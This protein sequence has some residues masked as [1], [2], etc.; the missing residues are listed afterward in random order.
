MCTASVFTAA[1]A[2]K[3]G[4]VDSDG[5][6]S[7]ADARLVLRASVGLEELSAETIKLADVD[8]DGSI[9]SADARLILRASVGLEELEHTHKYTESQIAK[10]PSYT[11]NGTLR[12]KCACGVFITEEIPMLIKCEHEP[13][14]LSI[15]NKTKCS[16]SGCNGEFPSFNDMVNALKAPGSLNRFYGFTKT[17]TV[18]PEPKCEYKFWD[19]ALAKMLEGILTDSIAPGTVT[20]YSDLT[21]ARHVNNATFFVLGTP[22]VSA[23]TDRDIKSISVSS[24]SG[25]DFVKNLPSTYTSTDSGE[26]YDLSKIKA[27]VIGDVYK[28]TVTLNDEKMTNTSMPT[29]TTPVEKI[30]TKN[31]NEGLKKNLESVNSSFDETPEIAEAVKMSMGIVT[32]GTVTYYFTKDAL[33]PVAAK[34]DLGMN[35]DSTMEI[36]ATT[37]KI[38]IESDTKQENF[39]FFN[40]FFK[41]N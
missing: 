21:L 11:E 36:N 9:S 18:T 14:T 8:F 2:A 23:L 4:D 26:R 7:S 3:L 12:L 17:T 16:V 34:Y 33:S 35:T 28:V 1:A 38:I 19:A 10:Y 20:E 22:H 6:I 29:G 30:F 15:E 25:V 13:K 39:F 32:T 40:N 24:M 37:I 31:Y 5:S 27:S 41:V